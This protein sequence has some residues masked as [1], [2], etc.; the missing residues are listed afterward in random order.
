MT[1]ILFCPKDKA[2]YTDSRATSNDTVISDNTPKLHK[3]N[4]EGVGRLILAL[5]GSSEVIEDYLDYLSGFSEKPEGDEFGGLAVDKNGR[6]YEVFAPS[7]QLRLSSCQNEVRANGSGF[8]YAL[9]AYDACGDAVTAMNVA[10]R[11]DV[12]SGGTTVKASFVNNCIVYERF[13]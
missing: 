1:T 9:A 11:R 13:K 4:I 2:L 8:Y 12:L 5:C 10:K 3:V 6:L 7:F